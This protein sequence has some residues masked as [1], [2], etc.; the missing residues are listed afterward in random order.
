MNEAFCA[1]EGYGVALFDVDGKCLS[2][3]G[4]VR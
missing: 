2:T 4:M 3:A 1:A